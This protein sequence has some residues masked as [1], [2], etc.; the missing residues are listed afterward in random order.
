[1][2]RLSDSELYGNAGKE[3]TG[4]ASISTTPEEEEAC[5]KVSLFIVFS[6]HGPGNGGLPFAGKAVQPKYSP[7]ILFIPCSY[8]LR[9]VNSSILEA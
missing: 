1:M 9:D 7:L 4:V 3:L 5:F 8:L 6:R 2:W